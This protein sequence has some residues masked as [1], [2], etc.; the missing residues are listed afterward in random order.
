V[1]VAHVRRSTLPTPTTIVL[2][3][4]NGARS[5]LHRPGASREAF[6]EHPE[7]PAELTEGCKWF[8][9]ANVFALPALRSHAGGL[10]ARAREAGLSVSIDTGWDARGEWMDVLKPCL[11]HADLLFVNEDEARELT[12]LTHPVEAA[13]ALQQHGIA[14][15]VVKLGA[16]GCALFMGDESIAC[17]AFEVPVVDTTGAGDCF[18]GAFLAALLRGLSYPDACVFANAVG[19][20]SV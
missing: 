15:V 2:V 18:V 5:L 20:L 1:D 9:L 17:P 10:L 3:S 6:S 7:L 16:A 19:A 8:H 12:G 14:N 11:P 4:S 13:R